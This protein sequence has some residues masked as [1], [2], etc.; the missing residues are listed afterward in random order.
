MGLS[1]VW[2]INTVIYYFN[3]NFPLAGEKFIDD[4]LTTHTA[5]ISVITEI[6]LLC[7]RS[8]FEKDLFILKKFIEDA[9]IYDLDEI[10]K[11]KTIEIRR[12]Y[13]LKLP[14]AIITAS[15]I[16]NHQTLITRNYS[17]FGRIAELEIIAPFKI[18]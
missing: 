14:D 10:I 6:E 4:I 11:Q 9:V 12:N 3:K 13:K 2:D 1:Y 5:A 16:V 18:S 8:A 7:W 15:A 17:D